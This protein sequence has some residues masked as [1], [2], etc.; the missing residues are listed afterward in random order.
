MP[1]F[2][3]FLSYVFFRNT[4][5]NYLIFL[6]ALIAS[7]VA[8]KI[9]GH[10]IIKRLGKWLKATNT[11]VD[12]L[13]FRRAKKYLGPIVYFFI[14]YLNTKILILSLTISNILNKIAFTL[15]VILAASLLSS[16]TVFFL[17]RHW[18]KNLKEDDNRT[19][20]KWITGAVKIVIW[21]L[22]LI[23]LIDNIAAEVKLNSLLTGVGI[24][25]IAI[26][27]AA[28]SILS[29][30]FCFFTIFFDR[31]FEIGDFVIAGEQMGTV[32]H[33]GL[34]TT[35]LR[36]LNGEQLIFSNADLTS[37]CIKNYKTMQQRR[38]LFTIGVKYDTPY[39]K[40]KEIPGIIKRIVDDVPGTQFGRTHFFSYGD[41]S[42]NFEIAY[43][44]LDSDYDKYMDINQEINLRIKKEFDNMRIEFAFPT[45][46]VELYNLSA[47]SSTGSG[48]NLI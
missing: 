40:L 10:F 5:L 1:Q 48:K 32:E 14:F 6:I 39:D 31:P 27:F 42:L 45:H 28:Q 29:D 43:Y 12:N 20:L 15:L 33:I 17:N 26:A 7:F 37:T 34:K 9:I 11:H 4:V 22:A 36:S 3:S 44:V 23:F 21:S 46:T 18:E 13:A 35:R 30:I 24:G 19:A 8:I 41:Y 2:L 38:V 47:V 16:V 25:S